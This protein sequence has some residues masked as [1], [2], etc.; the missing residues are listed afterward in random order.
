LFEQLPAAQPV[1]T[2][3]QDSS[4]SLVVSNNRHSGELRET[5]QSAIRRVIFLD[6]FEGIRIYVD[7]NTAAG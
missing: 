4:G 1:V 7:Q 5:I 3:A 6:Y 2:A